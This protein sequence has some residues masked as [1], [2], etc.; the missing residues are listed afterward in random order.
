M[1][2]FQCSRFLFFKTA[3]DS[4]YLCNIHRIVEN[5]IEPF[6]YMR[7]LWGKLFSKHFEACGSSRCWIGTT[8]QVNQNVNE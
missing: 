2:Y 4:L 5:S 1:D 3:G 6:V 7:V 8:R